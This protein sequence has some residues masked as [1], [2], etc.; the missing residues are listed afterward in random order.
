MKQL[1]SFQKFTLL[2]L[3]V[4]LTIMI[5]LASMLLPV[6][7]K[8]KTAAKKINCASNMKQIGVAYIS[9]I[10]ENDGFTVPLLSAGSGRGWR[11]HLAVRLDI[12]REWVWNNYTDATAKQKVKLFK[13]P[14]DE[15]RYTSTYFINSGQR[16]SSHNLL[17]GAQ[18]VKYVKIHQP[19]RLIAF[20]ECYPVGLAEKSNY[21]RYVFSDGGVDTCWDNYNLFLN[22]SSFYSGKYFRI[23]ENGSNICFADGHVNYMKAPIAR[24]YWDWR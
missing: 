2:E 6:L 22:D 23:H 12:D 18:G 14:S 8:A 19:A 13:C 11:W 16:A 7:Q 5:I 10:D 17:D 9:Y 24:E 1:G 20:L 4:V 15:T 21:A 3:L